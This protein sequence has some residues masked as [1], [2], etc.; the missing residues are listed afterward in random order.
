MSI[1]SVFV[2]LEILT[3]SCLEIVVLLRVGWLLIIFYC[4]WLQV[5]NGAS[6]C[7]FW[8]YCINTVGWAGWLAT[9]FMLVFHASND[10]CA[11]FWCT[12]ELISHPQHGAM[13]ETTISMRA[14]LL[15]TSMENFGVFLLVPRCK[16]PILLFLEK[17]PF[18]SFYLSS[19]C[20]ECYVLI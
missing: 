8:F 6:F 16:C 2:H 20:L 12:R 7:V 13:R 4:A 11:F 14:Q 1:S 10:E 18:F 5:H 19:C 3:L 17:K 15:A 9:L